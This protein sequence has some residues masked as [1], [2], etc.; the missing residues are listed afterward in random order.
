[1]VD[2]KILAASV[3]EAILATLIGS[4][5]RLITKNIEISIFPIHLHYEVTKE[6]KS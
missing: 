4:V 1:M 3:I 2:F 6:V 5:I